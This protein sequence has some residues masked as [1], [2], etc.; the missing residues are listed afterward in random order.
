[1]LVQEGYVIT[2]KKGDE[3]IITGPDDPDEDLLHEKPIKGRL[4]WNPRMRGYIGLKATIEFIRGD[5]TVNLVNPDGWVWLPSWL[6]PV[7]VPR[8]TD[9]WEIDSEACIV[10]D[11]EIKGNTMTCSYLLKR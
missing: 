10:D 11:L 6:T 4:R 7:G 2:L 3:V 5:G 1:V 9:S 8:S